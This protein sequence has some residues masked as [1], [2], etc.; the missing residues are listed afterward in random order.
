MSNQRKVGTTVAAIMLSFALA[1]FANGQTPPADN[2]G[3][4]NN[5]NDNANNG[6]RRRFDPQQMMQRRLD[7]IKQDLGSTDEEW[8]ALSPKVQKVVELQQQEMMSRFR[9][10]FRRGGPPQDDQANQSGVAKA[11][12]DLRAA[13]DANAPAD[14]LAKKIQAVRDARTQEQ[15][16]MTK[17]QQDLKQ[18]LTPKQE[19]QLVLAGVLN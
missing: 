1:G 9:G 15:D 14:E 8:A 12:A 6:R 10:R 5:Q 19:A 18:L 3:G 4:A 13:V 7:Q 17:A 11:T 2:G 16:E